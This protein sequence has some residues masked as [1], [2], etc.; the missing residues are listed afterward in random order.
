MWTRD[1]VAVLMRT[2]TVALITAV[3]FLTLFFRDYILLRTDHTGYILDVFYT[4]MVVPTVVVNVGLI[5]LGTALVPYLVR[6]GVISGCRGSLREVLHISIRISVVLV[7]LALLLTRGF[8]GYAQWIAPGFGQQKL[9]DVQEVL[10]VG[11]AIMALG[12]VMTV[13][14]AT[15]NAVGFQVVT[16]LAQLAVPIVAVVALALY[17]EFGAITAVVGMLAGQLLNLALVSLVLWFQKGPETGPA[18]PPHSDSISWRDFRLQYLPLIGAALLTGLTLPITN[19]LSATL[20]SGSVALFS[21][22]YKVVLF[23]TGVIATALTAVVVP[24][25]VTQ[26]DAS[27][28][29][30]G[31]D[32]AFFLWF[33]TLATLPLV[34]TVYQWADGVVEFLFPE[35]IVAAGGGNEMARVIKFGMVQLPFFSVSVVLTRF[36]I[37][38]RRTGQVFL[39]A[40][41]AVSV[42]VLTGKLLMRHFGISGIAV[43]TSLSTAVMSIYL[44][45]AVH[46]TRQ[47][48]TP[49]VVSTL[50]FWMMF[51]TVSICM[52]Y[53]SYTGIA[54]CLFAIIL[55]LASNRD[56][57]RPWLRWGAAV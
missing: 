40:V 29:Q 46:R 12:G 33:L 44:L 32:A 43:A 20:P 50:V 18:M 52:Y 47:I 10:A 57:I 41:V 25:F 26:F 34:M 51:V 53:A 6:I 1:R 35:Q 23:V 11:A 28:E 2:L 9:A 54:I 36:L 16:A 27:R 4:G 8:S 13:F 37:A 56:A 48:S 3:T 38:C 39:A 55:L 17:P 49:H 22:G 19:A 5:P 30:A 42:L 45:V 24:F 21:F 14:N 7:I 15:L 31:R